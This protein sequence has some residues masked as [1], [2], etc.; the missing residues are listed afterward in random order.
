MEYLDVCLILKYRVLEIYILIV[1][2]IVLGFINIWISFCVKLGDVVKIMIVNFFFCLNWEYIIWSK[3]KMY[4]KW[5][6]LLSIFLELILFVS[7][8]LCLFIYLSLI[9]WDVEWLRFDFVEICCWRYFI[10]LWFLYINIYKRKFYW[11]YNF[12]FF[13]W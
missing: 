1:M 12:V 11:I 7:G 2:G 10:V 4:F 8:C 5:I 13:R 3:G 9:N 6:Y